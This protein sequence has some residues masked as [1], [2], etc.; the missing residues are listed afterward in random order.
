MNVAWMAAFAVL[1]F[2]EKNWRS[3]VALSKAVGL[4]CIAGGLFAI[5]VA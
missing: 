1:F 5:A 3:G 4:A 2:L